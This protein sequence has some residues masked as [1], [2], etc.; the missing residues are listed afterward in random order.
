MK[1]RAVGEKHAEFVQSLVS[2]AELKRR[3]D[4]TEQALLLFKQAAEVLRNQD[5]SFSASECLSL[6]PEAIALRVMHISKSYFPF[7][8]THVVF[9]EE[10]P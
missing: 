4:Q 9:I 6:V 10:T 3:Q 8:K 1:K 2:L 7:V 5:P